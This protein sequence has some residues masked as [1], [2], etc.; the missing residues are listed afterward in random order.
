VS[1][2]ILAPVA[3]LARHRPDHSHGPGGWVVHPHPHEH[4]G[5]H[6]ESHE[7]VRL[8]PKTTGG[9]TA[10]TPHELEA[11]P[12]EADHGHAS[13]AHFNLALLSA[14]PPLALPNPR[15]AGVLDPAP[16]PRGVALFHPGFP[17]PRPPPVLAPS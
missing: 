7:H 11:D 17:R 8:E 9:E 5:A 13:L 3:H 6:H 1:G 4:D 14:P 16:S 2:G 15:P 10:T 12:L